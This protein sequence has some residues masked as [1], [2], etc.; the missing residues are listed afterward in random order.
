MKDKCDGE[1]VLML[2]KSIIYRQQT[3]IDEKIK[4]R[5][6]RKQSQNRCDKHA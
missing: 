2:M 1:H 3:W 4:L 5:I 6:H